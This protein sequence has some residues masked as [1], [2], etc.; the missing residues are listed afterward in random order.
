MATPCVFDGFDAGEVDVDGRTVL[1]T[2]GGAAPD[3]CA[4]P[5][6]D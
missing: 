1:L 2:F 3:G 6:R 4:P 5:E